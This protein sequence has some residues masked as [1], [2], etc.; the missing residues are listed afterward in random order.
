MSCKFPKFKIYKYNLQENDKAQLVKSKKV[1]IGS[2]WTKINACLNI[3]P[4]ENRNRNAASVSLFALTCSK[5]IIETLEK[6]VFSVV[7]VFLLLI[8]N[9]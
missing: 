3:E 2:F 4:P 8:L 9:K 5:S 7:L 6:G 1:Q